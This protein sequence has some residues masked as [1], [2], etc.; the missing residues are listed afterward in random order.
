MTLSHP[1]DLDPES[2]PSNFGFCWKTNRLTWNLD[3]LDFLDSI[4]R[5]QLVCGLWGLTCFAVPRMHAP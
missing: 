5:V 4:F 3:S 1:L 2:A